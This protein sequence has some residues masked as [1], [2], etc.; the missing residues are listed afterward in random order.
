MS[1][2]DT[3]DHNMVTYAWIGPPYSQ[4]GPLVLTGNHASQ[5]KSLSL[6]KT[7]SSPRTQY[8]TYFQASG[9]TK[10]EWHENLL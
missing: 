6:A 1:N 7:T 10:A 5:A 8:Y 4:T 2:I 9:P 3:S